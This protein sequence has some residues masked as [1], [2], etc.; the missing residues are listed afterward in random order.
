MWLPF[1]YATIFLYVLEQ[2][3]KKKQRKGTYSFVEGKRSRAIILFVSFIAF[4]QGEQ[5]KKSS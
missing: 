5:T 1:F 2:V 4:Q 3:I